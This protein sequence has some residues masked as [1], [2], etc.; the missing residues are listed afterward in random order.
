M[1]GMVTGGYPTVEASPDAYP[2]S[3]VELGESIPCT[4]A[5]EEYEEFE[6]VDVWAAAVPN[7][8]GESEGA[9]KAKGALELA[10]RAAGAATLPKEKVGVTK[11][12]MASG[13]FAVT[14]AVA[15]N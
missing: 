1:V 6:G 9:P 2:V 13:C 14:V 3:M 12:L 8:N 15:P 4:A 11:V 5:E 7:M 10:A